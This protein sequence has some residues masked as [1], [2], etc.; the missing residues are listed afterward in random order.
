MMPIQRPCSS[1][2]RALASEARSGSSSL[3]RDAFLFKT[4]SLILI[5]AFLLTS[6][7]PLPAP[8]SSPW[9][10]W[11]LDDVL[12]LSAPSDQLTWVAAY[13]RRMQS[14]CQ[15]RFD[16][17]NYTDIENLDLRLS[18][19]SHSPPTGSNN[20][21]DAVVDIPGNISPTIRTRDFLSKENLKIKVFRNPDLDSIVVQ[22]PALPLCSK[23]VF[24]FYAEAFSPGGLLYSATPWIST[25]TPAIHP[26]KIMFAFWYT[27]PAVTPL[28]LIRRWDG[29]HTGPFGQRHGLKVLLETAEKYQVP[30]FLLDLK[31][32]SSL[33]GL[34]ALGMLDWI[35]KLERNHILSL[36]ESSYGSAL[37]HRESLNF[38]QRVTETFQLKTSPLYFSADGQAGTKH[39]AYFSYSDNPAQVFTSGSSKI[40]PL[41]YHPHQTAPEWMAEVYSP[42]GLS[43]IVIQK[44]L[45]GAWNN[46]EDSILV[47]GGSLPESPLG[48]STIVEPVLYYVAMHPWIQTATYNDLMNMRPTTMSINGLSL[49]TSSPSVIEE[50]VYAALQESP[51]NEFSASAWEMFFNLTDIAGDNPSYFIN[52]SYLS[53]VYNL[54]F[55]SYWAQEPVES[56]HCDVDLDSD[57]QPECILSN[58]KILM[59][60]DPLGGRLEFAAGCITENHC[61][62][63]L[64][65]TAQ[66]AAGLSDP[67][68][69]D[70]AHPFNPDGSIIPGAFADPGNK[71]HLYNLTMDTGEIIF[72]D[73]IDHITKTFQL[74]P[75]GFQVTLQANDL[76]STLIPLIIDPNSHYNLLTNQNKEFE[77]LTSENLIW[78][79]PSGEEIEIQI[80]GAQFHYSTNSQALPLLKISE[81]PDL[82]YPD[83][84][85]QPFPVSIIQLEQ[86]TDWMIKI[87]LR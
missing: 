46:E 42:D 78:I 12:W 69:W 71:A 23:H 59:I 49:V 40:F 72:S 75:S 73:S 76:Y 56:N 30:L 77:Q 2:D 20:Q 5:T 31:E 6:C 63:W 24:S 21:P 81:D 66:F 70:P 51:Q 65:T 28:Q 33:V 9:Q 45:E 10:N 67:S 1:V 41:P 83:I 55:A 8:P 19:F 11:M 44:L 27:L 26:A 35:T 84:F 80:D 3:P 74:L 39:Q 29:A 86:S 50:K 57:N 22:L 53:Q 38:S 87:F 37:A 14:S 52:Q 79:G 58:R 25:E 85:Y 43:E 48:D 62:Q 47:L 16:F 17:L 60:L 4:L 7:L 61:S 15:F 36:A 68:S 54:I 13:F 18:I 64:G 32:P 34:E 82:A